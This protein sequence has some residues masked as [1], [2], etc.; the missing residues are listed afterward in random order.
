M[1]LAACTGN[2]P[3][4]Y[5]IIIFQSLPAKPDMIITGQAYVLEMNA[6][7]P[8]LMIF[9]QSLGSRLAEA[10]GGE[11]LAF[12]SAE[13]SH[14]FRVRTLDKKFAYDV[15]HPQMM[16]YLLA[17]QDLIIEIRETGLAILFEDWLR[18]EKLEANL[19]RLIEIR[20]LLPDYLFNKH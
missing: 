8:D 2:V 13:F 17:N 1:C 9:H 11:Q 6:G 15:C 14:A 10:F 12:E 19:L 18:P 4:S 5:L 7:F 20:R 3:L 16:E